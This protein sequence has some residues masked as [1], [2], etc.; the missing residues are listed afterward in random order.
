MLVRRFRCNIFISNDS[1]QVSNIRLSN[2]ESP[3]VDVQQLNLGP[4]KD[5]DVEPAARG[6]VHSS[7]VPRNA[8]NLFCPCLLRLSSFL[9][10]YFGLS[11]G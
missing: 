8:R 5:A 6:G 1:S 4:E 7:S 2:V 11:S 3:G 9:F 10:R